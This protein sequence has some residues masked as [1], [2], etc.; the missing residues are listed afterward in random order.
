[1]A[2][3]AIVDNDFNTVMDHFYA[4]QTEL[5]MNSIW[6]LDDMGVQD[7]DFQ[8]FTNKQRLVRYQ[9]V[10]DDATTE[11]IMADLADGGQRSMAEVTM[12]AVNGTIQEL[13]RAAESCIRQSG[14]HHLFIEDF[15]MQDDG[16]LLLIT[17]S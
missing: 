16:S 3:A 10:R 4:M 12:F 17:G 11:D 6:S 13:W 8:L 5:G 7:A 2:N 14:T 15:E 9:F 1:M